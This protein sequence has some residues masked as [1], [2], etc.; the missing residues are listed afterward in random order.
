[1]STPFKLTEYD[2]ITGIRTTV[3]HTGTQVVIQK[4]EDVDP[5]LRATAAERDWNQGQ[6]WGDGMKKVGTVP[7]SVVAKFMRQ[8]G[9]FDSKR[10]AQWL[11]ENPAFVTYDR[12]LLP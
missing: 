2:P 5:I 4:T 7:M 3:H 6:R 11:K 9:G 8:D 12:F 1:M 10:C